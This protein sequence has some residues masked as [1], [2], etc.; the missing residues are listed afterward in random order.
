MSPLRLAAIPALSALAALTVGC[1]KKKEGDLV[2]A[3]TLTSADAPAAANH[4]RDGEEPPSNLPDLPDDPTAPPVT[5]DGASRPWPPPPPKGVPLVAA[6]AVETPV[7]ST[8]DVDAPRLGQLRAGALVEMDPRAVTGRGCAG[9]Y[10][11]IKPMGFVCLGSATLELDHPIVRA[12]SRRP[13]VTSRLP[14]IYGTATRG[15]PA[16]A[17][18]PTA[19]D[20]EAFEPH[21][22]SHL[23]RWSRDPVNGA[24]YGLDVWGKWKGAPLPPALVAMREHMTDPDIPWF[25]RDGA[26]TPNLSGLAAGDT[27]KAGEFSRSNGVAFVD[28]F[29]H[30]GRR[31]NVAVDLRMMPADRF[32]PIRGSDFHGLRIPEDI[33]F[34][35]AIVRKRGARA[36]RAVGKGFAKGQ[37]LAYRSAVKLTGHQRIRDGHLV[38]ETVDGDWVDDQTAS[39]VRPARKMP[40][41]AIAGEKW[42]DISVSKQTLIAYEGTKPVYVTLVS[43]GEAGLGDPEKSRATTRGIFRIHTKYLTATMDSKVV[44]EEFELRD[45]PYVQYFHQGYALHAA[46]WHDVFGQPKS[47]GC[48]NLAPED[49]R[50]LFFWTG[51]RVPEGWHGAAKSRT[52]TVVFIHP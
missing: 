16:Y 23:R 7:L 22:A 34:P 49:A 9:G 5:L 30:Q 29:L 26:R 43:T 24:T 28:S 25:V 27:A 50:R 3:A 41:W 44:G 6:L 51:P 11:K 31:Y 40:G 18:L 19:K 10:R 46:Y 12:S 1:G 36:L 21:L 13:D 8:P 52:G 37:R 2:A 33:D 48:I 42:I 39:R 14:Y 47:H 32:R 45:V 15:G 17:T 20:L 4:A 35:F 38:Y